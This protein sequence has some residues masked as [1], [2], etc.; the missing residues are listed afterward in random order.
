MRGFIGFLSGLMVLWVIAWLAVAI[1]VF[2]SSEVV[3][4]VAGFLLMG[5]V[6]GLITWAVDR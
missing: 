4:Y 2:F 1:G 5:A 6:A 3:A